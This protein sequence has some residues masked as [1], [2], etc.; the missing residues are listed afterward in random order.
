MSKLVYGGSFNPPH[1]AH[2]ELPFLVIGEFNLDEVIYLPASGYHAFKKKMVDELG[3]FHRNN[4][5]EIALGNSNKKKYTIDYYEVNSSIENKKNTYTYD[6]LV[7]LRKEYGELRLL[8]GMDNYNVIEKWYKWEKLL[9]EFNPVIMSRP[10]HTY[11]NKYDLDIYECDMDVSSSFIK[12]EI[13]IGNI[14]NLRD[15][16]DINVINYIKDNKLY[17]V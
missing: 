8:M 9:E 4:L 3:I 6:S 15:Y 14:D 7:E 12:N 1:L 10:G 16:L 11:D 13:S 2:I 5:L 17:G